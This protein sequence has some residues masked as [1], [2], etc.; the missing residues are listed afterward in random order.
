MQKTKYQQTFQL[1]HQT[2]ESFQSAFVAHLLLNCAS[3]ADA[4]LGRI[5][6]SSFSSNFASSVQVFRIAAVYSSVHVQFSRVLF[7]GE[8]F[9]TNCI[10]NGCQ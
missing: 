4:I 7:Q 9:V 3:H 5:P 8:F 2:G 1:T 6:L 10:S